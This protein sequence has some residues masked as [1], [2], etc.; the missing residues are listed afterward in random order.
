MR[1]LGLMCVCWSV[2]LLVSGCAE[3]VTCGEGTTEV[4]GDCLIDPSQSVECGP[5]TQLIGDTCELMV[6]RGECGAGTRLEDG[7][8]VPTG[9]GTCGPGT[10]V[11]SEGE[12]VPDSMVTCGANTVLENG[13]CVPDPSASPCGDNTISE[14]G[15]CVPDPESVCGV[16]TVALDGVCVEAL[17][18]LRQSE[19]IVGTEPDDPR[20]NV[21]NNFIQPTPFT[22]AEEGNTVVLGGTIEPPTADSD[23]DGVPDVPDL[24]WFSFSAT[25]GQVLEITAYG[26]GLPDPLILLIG[27]DEG[28]NDFYARQSQTNQADDP[29]RKIVIPVDGN[30]FLLISESN[31]MFGIDPP[32]GSPDYNYLISVETLPSISA[33]TLGAG[34]NVPQ[35]LTGPF[36][37]ET[38][39]ALFL[40]R[41]DDN[42]NY[43]TLTVDA[44]DDSVS[45]PVLLLFDGDMGFLGEVDYA[46]GDQ[47]PTQLP[48][49][50]LIVVSD[51][52]ALFGYPAFDVEIT[53]DLMPSIA[54]DSPVTGL[55]TPNGGG[56]FYTASFAAN[57]LI[58]ISLSN[59]GSD[60]EAR[61]LLY[62]VDDTTGQLTLL[63][64]VSGTTTPTRWFFTENTSALV[65]VRDR[66]SET[67]GTSYNFDITIASSAVSLVAPLTS[68]RNTAN[69]TTGSLVTDES[70]WVGVPID[71]TEAITSITATSD[72]STD[73]VSVGLYVLTPPSYDS[74]GNTN[75]LDN[76]DRIRSGSGT[77]SAVATAGVNGI[78]LVEG[79]LTTGGPG[80]LRVD[81]EASEVVV[82]DGTSGDSC[83]TA[84][85]AGAGGA[86]RVP[87][88]LFTNTVSDTTNSC[89][90]SYHDDGADSWFKV[91]VADG[92]TVA[93]EVTGTAA[94]SQ[95]WGGEE[96][97]VQ[98]ITLG[99][100]DCANLDTT[101]ISAPADPVNDLMVCRDTDTYFSG[102]FASWTNDTGGSINVLVSVD[103]DDESGGYVVGDTNLVVVT[104]Q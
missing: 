95:S 59:V 24:D 20:F 65:E 67:S 6:N 57:E 12:C 1:V 52:V 84:I 64:S 71:M 22:L 74:D 36:Q 43:L 35:T 70:A 32:T 3:S 41:A 48:A 94:A 34:L 103:N 91:A 30:Y 101:H 51:W 39:N 7:Q 31:N 100:D 79:K 17:E 19:P 11:N 13:E 69:T 86:W 93:V 87:L 92:Q 54:V 88:E 60:L 42:Q 72:D 14:N 78:L 15:V 45:I 61:T 56:A 99:S 16:G 18:A 26:D 75:L 44:V 37:G 66:F 2:L 83:A 53:A 40:T 46:A 28:V 62:A 21:D 90:S 10:V 85:D 77:G 102:T 33:D 8:C 82:L 38:V 27:A 89:L 58:N 73:E 9:S 98:L 5:G 80:T 55:S 96:P 76:F 25:A 63:T 97:A 50:G 104:V 47:I 68:A 4:E 49:N 81:A 23:N 29:S